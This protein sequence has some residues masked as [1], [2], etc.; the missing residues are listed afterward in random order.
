MKHMKKFATDVAVLSVGILAGVQ[1]ALPLW[2]TSDTP[3]AFAFDATSWTAALPMDASSQPAAWDMKGAAPDVMAVPTTV[4]TW[5]PSM[6]AGVPSSDVMMQAEMPV[7][8][9][10]VL[11]MRTEGEDAAKDLQIQMLTQE[12]EQSRAIIAELQMQLQQMAEMHSAASM[13]VATEMSEPVVAAPVS[14]ADEGFLC[15]YLGFGC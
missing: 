13:P 12:L 10:T 1:V 3:A 9:P 5:Q 15:R 6:P 4:N 7:A 8:M 11:P 14:A 2:Q